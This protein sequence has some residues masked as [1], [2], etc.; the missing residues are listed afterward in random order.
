M[1]ST[2]NVLRLL[3]DETKNYLKIMHHR[4]VATTKWECK[5]PLEIEKR[6]WK[7]LSSFLSLLFI[8]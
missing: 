4:E 5:F 1:V 7:V 8:F 2:G 3:R 6:I